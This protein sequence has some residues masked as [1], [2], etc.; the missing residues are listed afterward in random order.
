MHLNIT[1]LHRARTLFKPLACHGR[2]LI[3]FFLFFWRGTKNA[4]KNYISKQL[5]HRATLAS[6]PA[7][8]TIADN[9]EVAIAT[10]LAALTPS[11]CAALC[12]ALKWSSCKAFTFTKSTK[13][14]TRRHSV[15]SSP[16]WG[17]TSMRYPIILVFESVPSYLY[18]FFMLTCAPI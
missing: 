15:N 2:I 18:H 10:G 9:G 8:Q 3:L 1:F 7:V 16:R 11:S 17:A 13:H 5:I 4:C 12:D 14:T 6:Y